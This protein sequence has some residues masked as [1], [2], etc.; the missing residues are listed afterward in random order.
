M[1]SINLWSVM[2]L[3][4]IKTGVDLNVKP[5]YFKLGFRV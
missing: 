5:R 4:G 2:F 3:L 1:K